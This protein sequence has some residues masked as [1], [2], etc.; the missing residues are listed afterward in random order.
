MVGRYLLES[1]DPRA[2]EEGKRLLGE[3]LET[4]RDR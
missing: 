1:A 4:F 2:S 3:A